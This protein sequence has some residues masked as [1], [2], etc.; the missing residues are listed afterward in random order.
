MKICI[1]NPSY[2]DSHSPTQDVDGICDPSPYLHDHTCESH[3]IKK[4]EAVQQVEILAAQGF[5]VFI[6]LC[7]GARDEERPGLE[8]V[9]TL[10]RLGVPFTGA[11]PEFYEPSR[12]QMKKVCREQGILAPQGV[13]AEDLAGVAQAAACLHFP[14]IV[15]HPSSYAS[16]GLTPASRVIKI[17][18]LY[19]QAEQMLSRFGGTL[20]EEFIEGREFTVLV[21][22]NPDNELEPVA[23]TPVEYRFPPGETFKHFNLKWINF[24]GMACVPCLDKELASRLQSASKKLFVGLAGASYARCDIRLN[25]DGEIYVLEINPNCGVFYTTDEAGGADSCL[26]FDPAG[27]EG[28]CDQIIR[29]AIARSQRR[30]GNSARSP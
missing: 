2:E 5:D 20:I 8:V 12:L 26:S 6:N 28:F 27:H 19:L 25:Q 18:D 21:A 29:A 11:T 16:I 7:D 24:R 10:E 9:K 23:Y 17:E 15:K 1:L 3:W 14:M 4:T 13:L 22:E 30:N